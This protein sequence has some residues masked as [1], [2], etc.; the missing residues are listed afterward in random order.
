MKLFDYKFLILLVLV[1]VV[2]FLYRELL[3]LKSKMKTLENNLSN[4][5][6]KIEQ[7]NDPLVQ[8]TNEISNNELFRIPLPLPPQNLEV[9]KM[10]ESNVI[11]ETKEDS[12]EDEILSGENL[13][14]YSNDNDKTNTYSL[15]DS[16]ELEVS[17]INELEVSEDIEIGKDEEEKKKIILV[18]S[19]GDNNLK[20]SSEK[21]SLNTGI[22]IDNLPI[23][24]MVKLKL[25]ELQC[26]AEEIAIDLINKEK[27]KKKTKSE[28]SNEIFNYYQNKQKIV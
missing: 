13:A 5:V 24:D 26:Y 19:E 17:E 3:D 11:L 23:S 21:S 25:N 16:S 12:E 28:L 7:I 27:N 6:K 4:N 8:E 20:D 10:E 18:K 15:G 2:Y 9:K 14:I 22:V 1:L